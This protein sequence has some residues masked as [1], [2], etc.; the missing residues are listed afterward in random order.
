V[1]R[2]AAGP[3]ALAIGALTAAP[4]A[5][6]TAQDAYTTG[7]PATSTG[8]HVQIDYESRDGAGNP[9]ALR[10]HTFAFPP[11]TVFDSG[12]AEVCTA[13]AA[14]IESRGLAACPSDSRV[15]GGTLDAQMTR[16]PG[17]MAGALRAR[18]E[19]FNASHPKD[20][21]QVPTALIVVVMIGDQ[22]QTAFVAPVKDNVVTEEPPTLCSTPGEQPPCPNGEITVK[23]VDYRVDEHTRT[24][25]GV[26][27]RLITTPPT[28]PAAGRW[29][30]EHLM[31]YRDGA[32]AT[33]ASAIPC[34]ATLR[35]RIR[36]SVTP[37]SAR[38]CRA[39]RFSFTATTA[40][41]PLAGA[42][43]RFANRRAVT[44]A[45]GRAAFPARI[46]ASGPRRAVVVAAGFRKG[47]ATVRVVR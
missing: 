33:A 3:A 38:R 17:S 6:T 4:A 21:P 14:E 25:D 1:R 40:S 32:T 9:R 10:K 39:R 22:V 47:S 37:S 19:I 13:S 18:L 30:F 7:V 11:G 44:D 26:Q 45:R 27:R 23:S 15:G 31:E 2:L 46:C 8:V 34:S 20:A 41:G 35:E 16:P 5:A 28:C 12:G 29:S 42:T 36:L 43:V 24:R